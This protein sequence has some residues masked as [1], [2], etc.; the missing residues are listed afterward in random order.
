MTPLGRLTF[1][2]VEIL[3]A[4]GMT[5]GQALMWS[6]VAVAAV[7]AP[8]VW[9]VAWSRLPKWTG[10]GFAAFLMVL[11]LALS[12]GGDGPGLSMSMHYNRWGWAVGSVL[13]VLTLTQPEGRRWPILDGLILGFGLSALVFLKA[14]FFVALV[15][16]IA[17][18]L[19]AEGRRGMRS[20]H[21]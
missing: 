14:T 8:V 19:L 21:R 17:F 13:V 3:M 1:L 5:P 6:Q 10:Y 15:P 9:Y 7:L 16:A 2:P 12:F 11:V 18:M 20:F 4:R